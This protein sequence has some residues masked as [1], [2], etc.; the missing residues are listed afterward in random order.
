[1]IPAG[2]CAEWPV[3]VP[4][5]GVPERCSSDGPDSCSAEG[6]VDAGSTQSDDAERAP[7]PRLPRKARRKWWT[8]LSGGFAAESPGSS[9]GRSPSFPSRFNPVVGSKVTRRADGASKKKK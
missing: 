3:A 8:A 4:A 7:V 5:G 9:K 6:E 2:G 1:M